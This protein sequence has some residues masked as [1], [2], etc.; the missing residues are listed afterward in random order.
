MNAPRTNAKTSTGE[1]PR[2]DPLLAVEPP[3]F[4]RDLPEQRSPGSTTGIMPVVR[5]AR[6]PDKY[7]DDNAKGYV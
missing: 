5:E 3:D 2:V 4:P 1:I 7:A 6:D